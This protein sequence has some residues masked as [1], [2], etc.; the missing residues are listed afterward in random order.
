MPA[1]RQL[2]T[3]LGCLEGWGFDEMLRG[4]P[5]EWGPKF[6]RDGGA[7]TRT[8][9]GP[10]AI[11][12]TAPVHMALI[13]FTP[14]PGR[15]IALNSDQ[16][17][18]GVAPAGSLEIVPEQSELFARWAVEK[19]NL[20]VAVDAARLE[21]LAGEEFDRDTFELYPLKLGFVDDKAHTLARW[22]R[23]EVENT[24]FGS[25]ECLDAQITVFATYLLRNH[26]SLKDRPSRLFNGGLSAGVWRR[27][28][29]F[30][31]AHL[32]AH[33]SLEQ[34]ASVA[35]L[36]PSHFA[37][38]FR[39]TTGQSPHQYVISSRLSYARNLIVSTDASLSG[40]AKS[41]GFSSNSHMTA[42]MRRTW[43]ATP[44]EFR[45]SR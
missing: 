25:G 40:V 15:Q 16:K 28:N 31:Q 13:M 2:R 24:D 41:A 11:H 37:R 4:V 32:S 14:Q 44:T 19:Q 27:V 17:T 8:H 30:I 34:L 42:M 22:M 9:T 43:Q 26:S 12:F 45:R 18:T 35:H 5:D 7:V 36:S 33:L 6:Q 39:Q 3:E 10:N 1:P 21:R 23:H 20:L 29:D 38:A